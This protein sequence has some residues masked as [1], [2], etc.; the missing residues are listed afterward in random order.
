MR[1]AYLRLT[2]AELEERA[3][4]AE[5]RLRACDLCPR[6]CGTDRLAGQLGFCRVGARARVGSW[7]AHFGEERILVGSGGSGTLFFSS[8]NLACVFCQNWEL[9]HL[10]EGDDVP[11]GRLA[12]LMLDLQQRGCENLNLVT[13]TP[14]SAAFLEAL[15]LAVDQ[16]LTLPIV[17]NTSGY[18]TVDALALLDGVVDIYMPDLKYGTDEAGALCS[19]VPDYWT[20]A[21]EALAEMHRQVGDLAIDGGLARRGLLVRHLVL[22]DDLASTETVMEFLAA[23][24]P[25]TYVNVMAQYYP[26]YRAHEY[27]E[28][29]RHLTRQEYETAMQAARQA[30]LH[31]FDS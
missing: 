5:E 9:S 22:P 13:P 24:S 19:Q 1:A 25:D 16:G 15:P 31:R 7:G 18:E 10:R 29:D 28:L 4:K 8:C 11:P 14:H 20:V 17:Y 6:R 30:G 2:R 26:T 23:L 27:P 21:R 3:E 12:E